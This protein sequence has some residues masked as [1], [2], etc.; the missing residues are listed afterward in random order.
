MGA[1]RLPAGPV[2]QV[3]L[4][5]GQTYVTT[6]AAVVT[7]ILG[8]CV[9]VCL[10]EP[11]ARVAAINHFLLARNPM[12]GTEDARYGDTAMELLLTSAL[13]RGAWAGRLVAKIFGGASVVPGFSSAARSIGAQNHDVALRTLEQYGVEVVA[14]QT[15]G[16]RG[17][18]LI[19]DTADGAAWV[20]E[21]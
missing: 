21:I 16:Q 9:A 15:G 7:T 1:L 2:E 4:H 10:W 13:Q 14:D 17:R 19:F 11:V 18:K 3:Y 6:D 5:P 8:S 12:R 20:K